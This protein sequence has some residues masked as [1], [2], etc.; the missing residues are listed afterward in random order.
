MEFEPRAHW[1]PALDPDV[2]NDPNQAAMHSLLP[3]PSQASLCM[4]VG[5]GERWDEGWR[6]PGHWVH[7]NPQSFSLLHDCGRKHLESALSII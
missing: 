4:D 2:V 1:Y 3:L 7:P 6:M 5:S